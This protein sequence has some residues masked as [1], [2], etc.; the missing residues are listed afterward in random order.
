MKTVEDTVLYV[1]CATGHP[2]QATMVYIARHKCLEDYPLKES[3]IIDYWRPCLACVKGKAKRSPLRKAPLDP[4]IS[5]SPPETDF[6]P[7]TSNSPT[8][9]EPLG[10]VLYS[11]IFGPFPDGIGGF[12]YSTT[13]T[14]S[15]GGFIIT[16]G[17]KA[18]SALPEAITASVEQFKSAGH[19]SPLL[20]QPIS[21]LRSD[22][23]A[24]YKSTAVQAILRA[25][26]IMSQFAAPYQH[27][28]A[29]RYR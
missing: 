11:D 13:F 1:H 28:Q 23:D 19:H 16:Y 5:S 22:S 3:D 9:I 7:T 12:K 27:E 21:I 26:G 2:S 17:M 4:C 6:S 24:Y 20:H 29:G 15:A 25:N 14:A 10:M 8:N 18:K